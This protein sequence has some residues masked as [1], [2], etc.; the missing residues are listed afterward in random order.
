MQ[1]TQKLL[2]FIVAYNARAHIEHVLDTIPENVWNKTLADVDVLV[3]DDC[4]PDDTEA[5]CHAYAKR[6]GRPMIIQRNTVN[7]GYGGNQKLGYQYAID[8]GYDAVILLHGD[9]QYDP[10]LIPLLAEPVLAG[11]ADVVIGSRMMDRQS[12]LRG[13]MPMY[14]FI[15]NIVLTTV[16]NLMLGSHLSEFHSGYRVYSTKALKAV[17]FQRNAN[18]FD[19]DT[20]IL[21]QMIDTKQRFREIA[22]PTFYG[23]EI[24]YVNGMKYAVKILLATLFSRLQRL[25]LMHIKKFDYHS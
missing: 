10:K 6:T 5:V 18:Y 14:K 15:G 22:I 11:E 8:H 20:D 4:S 13:G 19:F 7:Q 24:C 3:I 2:V 23:D 17:P 16:Q 21:I 1:K 25:G 9:G 12:A